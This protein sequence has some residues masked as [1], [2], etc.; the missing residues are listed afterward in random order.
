MP[1]VHP[2]PDR[3]ALLGDRYVRQPPR[4][5]LHVLQGEG[6]ERRLEEWDRVEQQRQ[7]QGPRHTAA[8]HHAHQGITHR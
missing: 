5:A 6:Q 1:V 2:P 8:L 4:H 3:A 7:R